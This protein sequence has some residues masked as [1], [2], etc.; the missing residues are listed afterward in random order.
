MRAQTDSRTVFGPQRPTVSVI[1]P[2]YNHGATCRAAVASM[3]SQTL[4]ELEV[5]VVDDGS[6]DDGPAVVEE[7]ARDDARIRLVS[8]T[9][10]GIVPAINAGLQVASGVYIAR[11]D[12]DDLSHPGRLAAQIEV[13]E[14]DPGVGAVDCRVALARSE[15]TG[16]GMAAHIDWLNSFTDWAHIRRE[17]LV[18]SPLVHPAVTMRRAALLAAGGYLD[19]PGP[20]DYSLWLRMVAAGF[21][22][23]KVPETLFTWRDLPGRLT[24]T[25][26][27][28][29]QSELLA[30]KAGHL[31]DLVPRA[32]EG[33]QVWG[34][35]KT[36]RKF[37]VHL[38]RVGVP[39]LRIFDIDRKIIG[40]Q[41]HGRPVLH[42]DEVPSHRDCLTLVALGTRQAKRQ[43]VAWCSE[44]GLEQG[45]DYLFVS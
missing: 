41:L 40:R 21:T 17:L 27:R 13:L 23:A 45:Q 16:E 9:H 26:K 36:G 19:V 31:F 15:V 35:G 28:Y 8:T 39:I 22:L 44:R 30:L 6:T 38:R 29:A 32:R 37:M 24:R 42:I 10:G 12:A 14:S 18:E 34:A 25:S 2:L 3:Q 1:L 5:V 43:V 20:E 11:M 4:Q 7:L 33:V